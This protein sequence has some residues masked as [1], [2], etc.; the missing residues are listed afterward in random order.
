M[1]LIP[2]T[3]F[4]HV[5]TNQ[6]IHKHDCNQAYRFC[7]PKLV[8]SYGLSLTLNIWLKFQHDNYGV[9]PASCLSFYLCFT[10][11]SAYCSVSVRTGILSGML[12]LFRSHSNRISTMEIK[13]KISF[14]DVLQCSTQVHHESIDRS[15]IRSVQIN[16]AN[17]VHN[18][19]SPY[20][21]SN[22]VKYMSSTIKQFNKINNIYVTLVLNIC[23]HLFLWD[24]P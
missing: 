9:Y 13:L 15:T 14:K 3:I 24:T 2:S 12:M 11:Y 22:I 17:N 7:Y 18:R 6:T 1:N 20:I 10:S 23:I 16:I 5:P 19:M 8:T 4:P 21:L